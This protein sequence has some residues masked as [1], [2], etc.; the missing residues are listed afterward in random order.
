MDLLIELQQEVNG[1]L[2]AR[3]AL[4]Y[5]NLT[6]F[7]PSCLQDLIFWSDAKSIHAQASFV[8]VF[9]RKITFSLGLAALW[10]SKT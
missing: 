5:L 4:P 2:A 1:T 9:A 7:I 8:L 3:T 6:A 10:G